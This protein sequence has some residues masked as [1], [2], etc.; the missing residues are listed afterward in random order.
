MRI[1]PNIVL[2]LVFKATRLFFV[3]NTPHNG[4]ASFAMLGNKLLANSAIDNVL[5]LYLRNDFA[6]HLNDMWDLCAQVLQQPFP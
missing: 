1:L 2:N 3:N 5:V 4:D 6:S